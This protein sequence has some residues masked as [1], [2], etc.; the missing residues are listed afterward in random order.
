MSQNLYI[1]KVFYK[2]HKI[3]KIG[4]SYDN[5]RL[6]FFTVPPGVGAQPPLAFTLDL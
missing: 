1:I 4:R 6:Q 2:Q 3:M 5:Q